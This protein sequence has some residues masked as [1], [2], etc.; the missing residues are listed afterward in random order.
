[1]SRARQ[2]W[3]ILLLGLI[4]SGCAIKPKPYT[5]QEL[6]TQATQRMSWINAGQTPIAEPIDL[7][8]AMDR[9][10]KYNL[11][12]R[13][14]A[15]ETG[16]RN[17]KLN[18]SHYS[19]LPTLVTNAGYVNRNNEQASSSR[20]LSTGTFNFS[21]S[22]STDKSLRTGDIS[23]SWNI[24]DFGLSYVRAHQAADEV[25]ISRELQR[26][27]AQK[28]LEKVRSAYWRAVSYQRMERKLQRIEGRINR[29]IANNR[30]LS[31]SRETNRL[32]SL[33]SERDLLELKKKIRQVQGNIVIAKA[34]LAALMN[35]KPGVPFTLAYTPQQEVPAELSMPLDRLLFLAVRDRPELRENMYQSRINRREAQAA[36]FEML[37]GLRA[38]TGANWDSNSYLLN[39][40]W[41]SWGASVSWNL[42]KVFQYPARKKLI[43]AQDRLI[44][45]RSL[46]LTMTVMTQVHL[47]RI[48]LHHYQREFQAIRQ[49]QA[50]QDRLLRQMRLE[51]EAHRV[52]ELELIREELGGILASVKYDI[53]Y[54]ELQNAYA[55]LLS[56]IGR[57]PRIYFSRQQRLVTA[58]A[59]LKKGD[60]APEAPRR[61]SV[62]RPAPAAGREYLYRLKVPA[63]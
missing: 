17:A 46:A 29:A 45:A 2:Y 36:L 35:V 40:N 30:T 62:V 48:R 27:L 15:A 19:M 10:L 16:L 34:E 49:H 44:H 12:R 24:L 33:I 38:F 23:F 56:S 13:V 6:T 3:H 20:N 28:L 5:T 31:D 25:L 22:T 21:S 32:S 55:N 60:D 39:T 50:V 59:A 53:T 43:N 61:K 37:P 42:L 1:M 63:S 4:V 11:D 58:S 26:K 14:K 18:L 57:D 8:E 41:I 47:S 51:F 52:S 7:Y 54:S 9:A